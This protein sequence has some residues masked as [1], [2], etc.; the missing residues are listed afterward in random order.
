MSIAAYWT[1]N[2]V[3]DFILYLIV[4]IV[5]IGIAK[6]MEISSLMKAVLLGYLAPVH[7][8]WVVLHSLH[9]SDSISFQRLRKCSG[10]LLFSNLCTWRNA[11]NFDLPLKNTRVRIKSYRQ[12]IS[13]ASS[14][15][16]IFCFRRRIVEPW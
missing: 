3:Y 4:A 2:F 1:A 12:R 8:L 9:I 15:I 7:F 16:S 14:L 13:L 5:T 11:S 10:S 6:G